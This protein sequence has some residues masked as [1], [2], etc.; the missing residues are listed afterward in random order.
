MQVF[1]QQF[2]WSWQRA[3]GA[4][5]FLEGLGLAFALTAHALRLVGERARVSRAFTWVAAL[6]AAAMNY[7]AAHVVDPTLSPWM[8]QLQAIAS[9]VSSL[10]AIVLWEVRSGARAR[11]VLWRSGRLP[12]PKP[13]L[14]WDFCLRF[15]VQAFW[16]WSAMVDDPKI[17]TRRKAIKRGRR[18]RRA[19]QRVWAAC[20]ATLRRWAGALSGRGLGQRRSFSWPRWPIRSTAARRSRR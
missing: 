8:A 17:R 16:A 12:Q 13:A 1:H 10:A 15:P 20:W 7:G 2:G 11:S 14:G 6:F 19:R 18:L 4:A 5:V 3:L 9:G